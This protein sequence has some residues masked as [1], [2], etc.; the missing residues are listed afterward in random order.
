MSDPINTNL[1]NSNLGGTAV[2]TSLQD[3]TTEIAS[4]QAAMPAL[5]SGIPS[6]G[7]SEQPQPMA[8]PPLA[9]T[10]AAM[11]GPEGHAASIP[12]GIVHASTLQEQPQRDATPPLSE[13]AATAKPAGSLPPLG[14]SG[15]GASDM[16]PYGAVPP[17]GDV[18]PPGA[19]EPPPAGSSHPPFP[20]N[21]LCYSI[22][23][24][25]VAYFVFLA[26]LLLALLQFLTVAVTGHVNQEL[27]NIT[28]S[29]VR[30]LTEALA[31]IVFARE[32]LPFPLQPHQHD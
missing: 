13:T 17:G 15:L 5:A 22:F 23:F 31:Y 3:S 20:W 2:S 27:K 26:I 28:H 1:G 21:R 8:T 19:G 32:E 18:P 10:A 16:P 25:V 9:E 4:S 7:L 11:R 24:A 29:L 12:G 14:S 6:S 30:Y